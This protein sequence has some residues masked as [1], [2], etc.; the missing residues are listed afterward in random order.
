MPNLNDVRNLNEIYD[1]WRKTEAPSGYADDELFELYCAQQALREYDVSAADIQFGHLGGGDEGGID[2]MYTFVNGRLYDGTVDLSKLPDNPS[3]ALFVIQSKREKGFSPEALYKIERSLEHILDVYVDPGSHEIYTQDFVAA[4]RLFQEAVKKTIKTSPRIQVTV[5]YAV[6]KADVS[7]KDA[8]VDAA[9][10]A[11][12]TMVPAKLSQAHVLVHLYDARRLVDRWGWKPS[13]V[14]QLPTKDY[15]TEDGYAALVR[16]S[17]YYRFLRNDVGDLA[18]YLFDANVRGVQ[19]DV[20]IN[21]KIKETVEDAGSPQFWWLNNGVTIVCETVTSAGRVL[22]IT[23][24]SVVNGLQT[25]WV[26]FEALASREGQGDEIS[27]ERVLLVR[28][29][30]TTDEEVR[31]QVIRAT[32]SQTPVAVESLVATEPLHRAIEKH[33]D[34][35]GLYYDRR[36]GYWRYKGVPADDIVSIR[37][38]AQAMVSMALNKPHEAR[39]RPSSIFKTKSEYEKVFNPEGKLDLDAYLWTA[40]TQRAIDIYLRPKFKHATAQERS[41]FQ[42]H[43]AMLLTNRA[44]LAKRSSRVTRASDLEELIS[45]AFTDAQI[46]QALDDVRKVAHEF[47][48]RDPDTTLD[49]IAK[50]R[51]FT[52]RILALYCALP[53]EAN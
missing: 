8:K 31:D 6:K 39:A 37:L 13:T 18:E 16:L 14:L 53:A 15:A 26:L 52:D 48:K 40:K 7:E 32:N 5:V 11:I 42:F 34:G 36:K 45:M 41:N 44:L 9:V 17:D 30:E 46:Q 25:S 20:D 51:E 50:T 35:K 19:G 12:E 28:V 38:L 47:E 49:Q 22:T 1:E 4:S 24:P 43:I 21:R 27:D 3:I 10:A 23:N 2:T 29:I 33:F